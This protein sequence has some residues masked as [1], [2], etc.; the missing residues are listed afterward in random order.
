[1]R[2]HDVQLVRTGEYWNDIMAGSSIQ[3][4]ASFQLWMRAPTFFTEVDWDYDELVLYN[5]SIRG[6]DEVKS[7]RNRAGEEHIRPQIRLLGDLA[8]AHRSCDPKTVLFP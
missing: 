2:Y 3:M 5:T 8:Y 6:T 7:R 1:M 4:R